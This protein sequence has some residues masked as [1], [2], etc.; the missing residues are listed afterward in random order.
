[1]FT[2]YRMTKTNSRTGK[3]QAPL[4]SVGRVVLSLDCHAHNEHGPFN[5]Q[6][7]WK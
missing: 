3:V 4:L 7:S 6:C 5:Q 1:M 2:R